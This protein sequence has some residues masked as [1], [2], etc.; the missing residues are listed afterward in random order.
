MSD[1]D[2]AVNYS[3]IIKKNQGNLDREVEKLFSQ[4]ISTG[5]QEIGIA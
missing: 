3:S 5:F 4:G 2:C 1:R